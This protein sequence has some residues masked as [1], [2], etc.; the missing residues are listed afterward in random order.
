LASVI[1]R[2]LLLL[3]PLTFL[4]LPAAAP[5]QGRGGLVPLPLT[6]GWKAARGDQP[7]WA[8]PAFDDRAW[9][10]IAVPGEW[11]KSFPGYDGFGWYRLRLSLPGD[12]RGE[13]VGVLFATVGDAYE[14]YWDGVK[15]GARGKLPPHFSEAVDPS[16]FLIPQELLRNVPGPHLLAVRVYNDYAYGGLMG[17]VKIGR[18]DVLAD[19]R[20]PRDTM[21]GALVAFFLAIGVYHLAFWV[22]RRAARENLWFAAVSAAISIY[23]ATFSGAFSRLVLPWANPYRVGLVALLAGGPFFVAL[24][25]ALFELRIRRREHLIAA[26]FVA[27]AAVAAVLPLGPL[28]HLNRWIDVAMAVGM[29]AIVLRAFRAASVHRR[30]HA[31]L[32]VFGTAAFAATFVY[33]LASEYDIV[34]V[35][36]L[37]GEVPSSFWIGFMVFVLAVGIATAGKWALTE[38]TALVDP[39]TELSRRHVLQDALRREA[40]RI[41]RSGGSL[42]LVMI[43]LDFFKQVNDAYGHRTGD[44]VLAR[45]GRLLRSTARNIDLAARFG[46]EEFA[47]LLYDSDLAG[48]MAFAERFR[49]HLREMAVPASGGRTVK[50]TASLGVAVG[51][52]LV[53]P[54]ALIDAADQALYRAKHQGRDRLE[55]VQL[56]AGA[57][58]H[59]NAPPRDR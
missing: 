15:I 31:G 35:A 2:L 41:R 27:T 39:L 16:L 19:R 7:Q 56:S 14:V 26:G 51:S 38:V 55:G 13:P 23:G 17:S 59:E 3:A 45:V 12:L 18:Y 47:V 20:S 43:D 34:P 42:A 9:T 10:P 4:V 57:V 52:V 11:E 25:Y 28:A 58:I 48:A 5:A 24:V 50:V 8:S 22:R 30:P 49:T 54:D 40:D 29:L 33:D 21:V 44:E 32:L 36:H 37:P 6:A 46:G 53:D 1:R